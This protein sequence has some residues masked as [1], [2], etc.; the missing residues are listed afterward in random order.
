MV[1]HG[2]TM[3]ELDELIE[4]R[5][6]HP[7]RLCTTATFMLRSKTGLRFDLNLKCSSF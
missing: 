6:P 3:L 7:F 1:D 5:C 4:H 2:E